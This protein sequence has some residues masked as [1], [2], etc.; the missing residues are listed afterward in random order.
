MQAQ[1]MFDGRTLAPNAMHSLPK[2]Q[3]RLLRDAAALSQTTSPT[4]CCIQAD[5]SGLPPL[6]ARPS[7]VH[8]MR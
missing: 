6:R 4:T 2:Y 7:T 5:C 1:L 3:D 8:H